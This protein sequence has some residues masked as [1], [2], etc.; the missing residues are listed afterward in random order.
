MDSG[1][2]QKSDPASQS[3]GYPL[4]QFGR[5]I[6]PDLSSEVNSSPT[7]DR[8]DT[9][10]AENSGRVG[11]IAAGAYGDTMEVDPQKSGAVRGEDILGDIVRSGEQNRPSIPGSK[12]QGVSLDRNLLRSEAPVTNGSG[13]DIT[14]SGK[15]SNQIP[16][17]RQLENGIGEKK[18]D[19]WYEEVRTAAQI[20]Y[21]ELKRKG[22]HE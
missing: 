8:I 15:V 11:I 9:R 12:E 6:N 22:G 4:D 13:S 7:N 14:T 16:D 21:R 2:P 17:I 20:N 3:M 10:S 5:P 19:E 1:I 18:V